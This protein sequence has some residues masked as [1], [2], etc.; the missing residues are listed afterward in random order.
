ALEA[1]HFA[2]QIEN[3]AEAIDFLLQARVGATSRE[4]EALL[5]SLTPR[6]TEP[7]IQAEPA[8]PEP[9][10]LQFA[11]TEAPALPA[12]SPIVPAPVLAAA[13]PPQPAR[14]PRRSFLELLSAFMEQ[15]NILWG[16][17]VGGLL[18]VVCSIA[19]VII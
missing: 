14:P 16:E 13:P 12:A 7:A 2:M 5:E 9:I 4:A 1:G 6:Q 15:S 18:I 11:E 17:L 10:I 3:R 19:L 8:A